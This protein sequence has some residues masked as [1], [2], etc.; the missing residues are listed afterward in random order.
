MLDGERDVPAVMHALVARALERPERLRLLT[1]LELEAADPAHPAHAW[2]R[3][4]DRT[5]RDRLAAVVRRC[6]E[7]DRDALSDPDLVAAALAALWRGLRLGLLG[8]PTTDVLAVLRRC[9][10]A[11]APARATSGPDRDGVE[12]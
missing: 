1:R 4:R 12:M 10:E 3:D 6:Q 2:F 7:R 8:D 9:S 5:L 11:L